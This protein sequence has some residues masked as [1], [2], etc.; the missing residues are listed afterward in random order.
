MKQSM[1]YR[2]IFTCASQALQEHCMKLLEQRY[3]GPHAASLLPDR[4]LLIAE[5]EIH[6]HTVLCLLKHY[7]CVIEHF[8]TSW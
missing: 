5:P 2:N 6:H 7:H 3:S 1:Y 4:H 8:Y